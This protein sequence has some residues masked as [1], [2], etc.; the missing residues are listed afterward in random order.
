MPADAT[1]LLLEWRQGNHDALNRLFPLV[2]H[3]LRRVAH[4]R[5]RG[6]RAEHTLGT[7]ALVHETYLK[8]VN[9]DR[10]AW[11]DRIHFL[12]TAS[13][14]MRRILVDYARRRCAGKRGGGAVEVTLNEELLPANQAAS[15]IELDD[16]LS[17]LEMSYPRQCRAVELHYF[18]GLTLEE[19]GEVLGVSAPT[20]MRDLRFAQAWLAR[21]WTEEQTREST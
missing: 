20:V 9:V 7:T 14:L 1:R 2:Y 12:A 6:E 21:A 18:G 4:A 3:E 5:L 16:A 11:R 17:Q 19:T 10:V 13:H 8:L 15:F